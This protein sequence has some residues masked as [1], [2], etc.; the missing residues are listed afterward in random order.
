MLKSFILKKPNFNNNVQKL[1]GLSKSKFLTW[2]WKEHEM[3]CR[4]EYQT[5]L[6]TIVI[7]AQS[8]K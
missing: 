6:S 1:V 5:T 8:M 3:I 2:I 4:P 7:I